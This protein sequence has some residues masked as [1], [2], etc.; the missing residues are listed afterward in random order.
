MFS[1]LKHTW[2]ARVPADA[3]PRSAPVKLSALVPEKGF[4][5]R[6]WD[7]SKGGYQELPVAPFAAFGEEKASASWLINAAYAA[8]WQSFQSKGM[9]E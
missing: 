7:V 3:D 6:N 1:F 2:A 5:G 9:V 8:D 4:L